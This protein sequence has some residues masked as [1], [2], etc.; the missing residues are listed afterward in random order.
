MTARLAYADPPYLGCARR[1]YGR[2]HAD[3]A[4][5]DDRAAH[6]GLLAELDSGAWHGWAYSCLPRD[7]E[8][9]LPAVPGARVGVWAKPFCAWKPYQRVAQAWEPVVYRPVASRATVAAGEH[10]LRVRD[11]VSA[12]MTMRRQL[13]GAKPE[14]F[15]RW[16]L[17][18][19]GYREGDELRDWFPG[20]SVLS[21][22]A[23]Q[24]VLA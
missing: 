24:G 3:A 8:W 15:A 9:V 18:L 10:Y 5:W 14:R 21:Q 13:P 22:V 2:H 7:L 12:P 6:L 23:A 4:R 19:L 1:L 11:Y 16:V 17:D 20:T